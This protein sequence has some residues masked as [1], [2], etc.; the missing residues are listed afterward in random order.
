MGILLSALTLIA[1]HE[2]VHWTIKCDRWME[3]AYEI[4]QDPYLDDASKLGLINHFK[5]KVEE[6][7]NVGET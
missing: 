5:Y 7:C 1:I 6:S 2:P 4:K 3:L